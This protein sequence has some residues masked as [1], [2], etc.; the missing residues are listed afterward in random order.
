MTTTTLIALVAA[1]LFAGTADAIAGGGGLITVPALLAAGLPPH[2]ALGTNK[3]QSI[4]GTLAALTTYWRAGR[5]DRRAA[6]RNAPLG[7]LGSLLGAALVL[8]MAPTALR[9]VAI[10]LLI[11][12]AI[13][14][15]LRKPSR[16]TED[17]HRHYL[18]IGGALA[19]VIGGYDGFFGPGTGTFLVVGF[20]VLCGRAM[21][22]ATADAKVVN[23]SSNLAA[24]LTFAL[25]GKVLWQVAAPMAAAQLVGGSLGARLAIHGGARLIRVVVLAVSTA[26]VVKLAYDLLHG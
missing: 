25:G 15:V 10:A 18:W 19:F 21:G 20:M 8:R 16:D 5:V 1:S 11:G 7:F 13:L 22:G 26:L 24:V 9:P 6:L 3:A 17:K 12:A 23:F 14:M 2:L 4:W